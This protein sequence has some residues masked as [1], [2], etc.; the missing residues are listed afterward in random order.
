MEDGHDFF[1]NRLI[2]LVEEADLQ[3]DSV[4]DFGCNQGG[5][6]RLLYRRKPFA[7]GLGID[8]AQTA[9]AVAQDRGGDLPI[10]YRVVEH[11]TEMSER[12][13]IAFS[14]EVVYLL[15]DIDAH[16]RAMH[17]RLAPGGVYYVAIGTHA[18]NPDWQRWA[19]EIPKQTNLPVYG[20]TLDEYAQAFGAAGFHVAARPLGFNGFV[21]LDL[22][23][24]SFRSATDLL[25]YVNR[26]KTIF[27]LVKSK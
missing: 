4:L 11:L 19:V 26:V 6:L 2:D 18:N 22:D 8:I 13:D 3:A 15:P 17:A 25:D 9:V 24:G 23:G 14:H 20:R 16:A 5:F 1:W 21:P 12:F 7:W 27:R 10:G